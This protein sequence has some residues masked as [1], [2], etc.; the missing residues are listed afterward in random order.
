M[1]IWI[2]WESSL[3]DGNGIYQVAFENK[4]LMKQREWSSLLEAHMS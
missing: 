4:N 2:A 3:V 1:Y